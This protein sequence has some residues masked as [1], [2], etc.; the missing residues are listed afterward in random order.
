LDDEIV[1]RNAASKGDVQKVREL[2]EKKTIFQHKTLM[3]GHRYIWLLYTG[4]TEW[5]RCCLIMAL[6]LPSSITSSRQRYI[7]RR[8]AFLPILSRSFWKEER[9]WVLEIA[10]E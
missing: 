2:L 10:K 4:T 7:L 3:A 6:T 5:S 1:L 9:M 8:N